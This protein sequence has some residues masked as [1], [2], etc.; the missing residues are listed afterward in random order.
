MTLLRKKRIYTSDCI[1]RK[2]KLCGITVFKKRFDRYVT[3]WVLGIPVAKFKNKRHPSNIKRNRK[4]FIAILEKSP[5]TVL[6]ID[7]SLGGGTEIYTMNSFKDTPDTTYIRF[8]CIPIYNVFLLSIFNASQSEKQTF[9]TLK[10]TASFLKQINFDEIVVNNI[11]GYPKAIDILHLVT[12]Y[13]KRKKGNVR[14]SFRGHDFH[15]IC[16]SFT[17]LNCDDQYCWLSNL[18]ICEQ[19]LAKK[20]FAKSDKEN[21]ILRSGATTVKE[22][23]TA[24]NTFFNETLD[25]FIVFSDEIAQIFFKVYPQLRE[26]TIVIPHK[27]TIYHTVCI[28]PHKSINIAFLGNIDLVVKGSHVVDRMIKIIDQYKNVKLKVIGKT[29]KLNRKLYSTGKYYPHE[30]PNLM[31]REQIDIVFIA[32]VA[33]ETFS[34]TTSEAMSMGL[35]IAC[36]NFGAPYERVRNYS[37]GL[38]LESMDEKYILDHITDFVMQIRRNGISVLQDSLTN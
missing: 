32:S 1:V 20:R 37:K 23:R 7:H 10:E 19:C 16:P 38:I 12:E 29:E 30:L 17:L 9:P 25:T 34:Y 5:R 2:Y 18:D 26:K 31:R 24:W 8:Q 35:P 22:W 14:V 3:M 13:K 21:E 15:A 36:F 4:N 11:V 27:T 6:W 28:K 33:P